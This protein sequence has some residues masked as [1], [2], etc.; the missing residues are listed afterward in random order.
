MSKGNGHT[1]ASK[2]G[3]TDHQREIVWQYLREVAIDP[4]LQEL[5]ER[6]LPLQAVRSGD[7]RRE[8]ALRD[9]S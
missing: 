7:P 4:A 5:W 3:D 1:E 6:Y 8:D 9:L 2:R